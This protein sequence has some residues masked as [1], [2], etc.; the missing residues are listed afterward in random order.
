MPS[1]PNSI[2]WR[3]SSEVAGDKGGAPAPASTTTTSGAHLLRIFSSTSSSTTIPVSDTVPQ[4]RPTLPALWRFARRRM[5]ESEGGRSG[6]RQSGLQCWVV[7]SFPHGPA[8]RCSV[9]VAPEGGPIAPLRSRPRQDTIIGTDERPAQVPRAAPGRAR[10]EL[11]DRHA[12][13]PRRARSVLACTAGRALEGE[14]EVERLERQ[15]RACE[16]ALERRQGRAELARRQQLLDAAKARRDQAYGVLSRLHGELDSIRQEEAAANAALDAWSA[17]DEGNT[18]EEAT[19]RVAN[20]VKARWLKEEEIRLAE[21]EKDRANQEQ[22]D[23]EL[24]LTLL[25]SSLAEQSRDADSIKAECDRLRARLEAARAAAGASPPSTPAGS[26]QWGL[27]EGRSWTEEAPTATPSAADW[28]HEEG[29][30]RGDQDDRTPTPPGTMPRRTPPA[31]TPT[32]ARPARHPNAPSTS[33]AALTTS[34]RRCAG[35]AGPRSW[36]PTPSAPPTPPS[37]T[38]C[39]WPVSTCGRPTPPPS[40]PSGPGP[41]GRGA[42]T[43]T[44]RSPRGSPPPAMSSGGS[45]HRSSTAAGRGRWTTWRGRSPAISSTGRTATATTPASATPCAQDSSPCRSPRSPSATVT[46]SRAARGT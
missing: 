23:E 4:N 21:E 30:S 39:A 3:T 10:H 6:G 31:L 20:A 42:R 11:S 2:A 18:L 34:S 8:S 41:T 12:I 24:K 40:T 25:Q 17:G 38:T 44:T 1:A 16:Q 28:W 35:S 37:R 5:S 43:T 14:S 46:A 36:R 33:A 45:S 29:S 9:L 13:A 19:A 22:E 27:E 7:R 26:D 32:P 15:V